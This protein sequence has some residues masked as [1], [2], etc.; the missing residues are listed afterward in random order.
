MFQS[1]I[2]VGVVYAFQTA[3]RGAA[4]TVETMIFKVGFPDLLWF[5]LRGLILTLKSQVPCWWRT[6]PSEGLGR[7]RTPPVEASRVFSLVLSEWTDA[8]GAWRDRRLLLQIDEGH[9]LLD[10]F[11]VEAFYSDHDAFVTLRLTDAFESIHASEIVLIH[12]VQLANDLVSAARRRKDTRD[13]SL[14]K[15]IHRVPLASSV[16][17]LDA[18][19]S[20]DVLVWETPLQ[21]AID[22]ELRHGSCRWA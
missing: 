14:A 9:V 11:R 19:A 1:R 7:T 22:E 2:S 13:I 10:G 3:L 15:K 18:A 17:P 21:R 4:T 16:L 6:L 20:I 5:A 12:L 8:R